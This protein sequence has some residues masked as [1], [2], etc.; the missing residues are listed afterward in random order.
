MYKFDNNATVCFFGDS[1]THGGT[2][3]T[4][5]FD[6]YKRNYR[7]TKLKFFNC[8]RGGGN[9]TKGIRRMEEDVLPHNP[10]DVVIM[11]GMNDLGQHLYKIDRLT[12][13]ILT[14]RIKMMNLY[15]E[16]MTTIVN[17]LSEKGIRI[18]LCTPTPRDEDQ[19]T[20]EPYWPAAR[21]ALEWQGRFVKKLAEKFGAEVVDFY[22][23]MT[24][25]IYR[26]REENLHNNIINP[27]RVHPNQLGNEV[28]A[29]I[30]LRAQGFDLDLPQ[31][32]A[33]WEKQADEP[34]LP[35]VQK[36]QEIETLLRAMCFV[37]WSVLSETPEEK[38][39]EELAK[40]YNDPDDS[41]FSIY[42]KNSIKIWYDNIDKKQ[43][44]EKQLLKCME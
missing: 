18:I 3:H 41:D 42:R 31:N 23:E 19:L 40:V 35:E 26:L 29:R 4:R 27:D 5:V 28:M 44:L 30:F 7:D 21:Y 6:Y 20:E 37:R 1:I 9:A 14:E 36:K 39:D 33:Y 11:F 10:T 43:E 17:R 8:G 2:W 25:M 38:W 24:E 32:I 12:E 15:E 22:S 34:Y 16:S 13:E